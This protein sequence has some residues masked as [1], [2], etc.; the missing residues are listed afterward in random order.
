MS[1]TIGERF[2]VTIFGESHGAAIGA[3]AEGVPAGEE[4]PFEYIMLHMKR[5]APGQK[6]T[7]PRQERD[8]P[9]FLSG[10][11]NGRA[12]GAPICFVIRNE[13]TRSG[14]YA[15]LKNLMRPGHA[16]YPAYVKYKGFNDYRGGGH[17]SGRITAPLT[18]AGCLARRLLEKRGIYIGAHLSGV[19]RARDSSFPCLSRE[20]FQKVWEKDFPCVGDGE[21]LRDEIN[22]ARQVGDSIG[23]SIECFITGVPAGVGEPFFD[24]VESCLSH[25]LFSVPGV[26]GIF[27]GKG[28]RAASMRGSQFNDSLGLRNGHI[29]LNSNNSGGING[30]ISNGMPIAFTVNMRPTPSIS[31][32]QQTVNVSSMTAETLSVRGRHDPCIA[33]RAVPVIE[34]AAA[35]ALYDLLLRAGDLDK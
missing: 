7:T 18:A 15:E 17:F 11:F 21:E 35:I 31:V 1:M 19:G 27:F 5:R 4:I 34:S 14:D 26:K 28:D 13:N 24:S 23:G 12:T 32:Q 22:A 30:G 6:G 25:I 2:K 9:E 10:V 29:E 20:E 3:V 8:E 16:D 33:V